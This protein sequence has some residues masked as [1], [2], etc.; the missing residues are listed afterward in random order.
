MPNGSKVIP[1]DKSQKLLDKNNNP[2]NITVNVYNPN[3]VDE[4]INKFAYKLMLVM[5]NS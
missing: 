1:A 4:I 5:N 3:D 2:I